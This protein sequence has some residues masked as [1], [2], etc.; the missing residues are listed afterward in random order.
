MLT[1]KGKKPIR[2]WPIEFDDIN[3]ERAQA[4]GP[5]AQTMV[6]KEP[7]ATFMRE[8]SLLKIDKKLLE[9]RC[10][11]LCKEEVIGARLYTGPMFIKESAD[12]LIHGNHPPSLLTS[13]F[14][15][16]LC[17]TTPFC[18][19]PERRRRLPQEGRRHPLYAQQVYYDPSHHQ[20]LGRQ[21][22]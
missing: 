12:S 20:Q 8:A 14:N 2:N 18:A 7:L 3:T 21:A 5:H 15:L 13:S 9:L 1:R 16:V 19:L 10:D 17:S 11:R 22:R 6:R 4:K